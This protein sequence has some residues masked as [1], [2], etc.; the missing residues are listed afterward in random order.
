MCAFALPAFYDGRIR[1]NLTGRERHGIVDPNDYERVCDELEALVGS[2]IDP[3]TGKHVVKE[4]ERPGANDPMA[5]GSSQSDVVVVWN[6]SV[7]ALEHPD[8]GLVG[9]V[10]FRRTG[11]HTG[12]Y[13]F[14][15]ISGPG[16]AAADH[17][18]RSAFDVAPTLVDL[19][20]AHPLGGVIV[21]SLLAVPEAVATGGERP[22]TEPRVTGSQW[23]L[24][25][26]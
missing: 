12:P 21:T 15:F 24:R 10:P 4:F 6:A 19:V 26:P 5:L 16:I 7:C 8:L 17:G 25:R 1:V 9:P 11:G 13:G 22:P 20:G 18:V 23:P 14:A 2:C 3:R